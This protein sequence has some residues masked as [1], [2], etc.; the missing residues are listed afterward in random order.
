MLMNSTVNLR[1]NNVKGQP[2][3]PTCLFWPAI[4][5]ASKL[6]IGDGGMRGAFEWWSNSNSNN[7][8]DDNDENNNNI[9]NENNNKKH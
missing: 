8:N 4:F 1:L 2:N 9:S 5:Q 6:P 7:S 3:S